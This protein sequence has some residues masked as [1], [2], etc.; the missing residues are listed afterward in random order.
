MSSAIKPPG[1]PGA[2]G[3]IGAGDA[4]ATPS[5][6]GTSE[7]FRDE[8]SK[9]SESDA[10]NATTSN[11]TTSNATTSRTTG[12]A[13]AVRALSDELRAGRVDPQQAIDRLVDRAL[14]TGPA[15]SLPPA[16]RAELESLLRAS[17]EEDPTLAAMQKDLSR[18]R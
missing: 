8:L 7:A 2:S 10:S 16:R 11:A 14:S 9:A 3:P 5:V 18:G 17:L 4:G 1:A 15:A 6:D 12:R 13:D